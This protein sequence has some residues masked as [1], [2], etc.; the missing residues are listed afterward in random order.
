MDDRDPIVFDTLVLLAI[1]SAFYLLSRRFLAHALPTLRNISKQGTTSTDARDDD[2]GF[3]MD[4]LD[5]TGRRDRTEMA[6]DELYEEE[7]ARLLN[8]SGGFS[9]V[10]AGM[11]RN[12]GQS[13]RQGWRRDV[14]SDSEDDM[15]DITRSHAGS[16]LPSPALELANG[17]E[18]PLN[19]ASTV[20]LNQQEAGIANV[21]VNDGQD[22]K[23]HVRRTSALHGQ[24]APTIR[25]PGVTHS[26][27]LNNGRFSAQPGRKQET[28]VIRLFKTRERSSN[29][30]RAAQDHKEKEKVGATRGLG[31][32]ARIPPY[33]TT[34]ESPSFNATLDSLIQS[35]NMSQIIN[36]TRR[37]PGYRLKGAFPQKVHLGNVADLDE[38]D[39][40]PTR[41]EDDDDAHDEDAY[42]EYEYAFE[43][44][45]QQQL[46]RKGGWL[47]PSLGRVV[48]LG[49]VVL[50]GLSGLGAVRT[51]WNFIE[52]GGLGSGYVKIAD[53]EQTN[54]L[55]R[56]IQG[57]EALEQQVERGLEAMK[58]R[59]K[60]QRFARTLRGKAFNLIGMVF[61]VYCIAR[62]TM[63]FTSVLF[64]PLATN[65]VAQSDEPGEGD[66]VQGKGNTN[67]DWISYLI[68]W[69]LSQLPTGVADVAVWS[70]AIS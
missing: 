18:S 61:A 51:A 15:S 68:A 25:T 6:E 16:P 19:G 12:I 69:G 37:N 30:S 2:G 36:G 31:F 60:R 53:L 13:T 20:T 14:E 7:D 39:D 50:G 26:G 33:V 52:S 40:T 42:E 41:P 27:Q 48:V 59:R 5:G 57:L 23:G 35:G 67:G 24:H 38:F 66:I 46:W 3:A 65:K 47:E 1:Q 43:Y 28:Q 4:P 45:S 58:L 21:G 11:Q 34:L 64:P 22:G 62:V 29:A 8:A 44:Y 56:E 49:V 55:R 9:D 17:L 70:R 63:C 32:L 54:S 10:E